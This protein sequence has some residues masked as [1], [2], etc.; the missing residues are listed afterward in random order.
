MNKEDVKIK[1]ATRA[2]ATS[3]SST[4][5]CI[6]L[7]SDDKAVICKSIFLTNL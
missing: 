7:K 6:P 4:K 2:K 5:R 1:G 3:E